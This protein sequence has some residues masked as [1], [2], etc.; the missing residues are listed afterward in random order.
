MIHLR[1]WPNLFSL[2]LIAV[3]FHLAEL[4]RVLDCLPSSMD[5]ISLEEITLLSD[6][7]ADMLDVLR[8]KSL[9]TVSI[10]TPYSHEQDEVWMEESDILD[11]VFDVEKGESKAQAYVL[12]KSDLN[13]LR[14]ENWVVQIERP[15]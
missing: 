12:G 5:D 6:T 10:L 4:K 2:R 11:A 8:G 9:D 14:S 7:L 1:P 15:H 13:P 3:P